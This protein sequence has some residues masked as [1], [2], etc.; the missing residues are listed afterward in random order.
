MQILFDARACFKLVQ[1]ALDSAS[2]SNLIS[3]I[4][5][6]VDPIDLAVAEGPM[7]NNVE[8][9]YLHIHLALGVFCILNPKPID[10]YP[11]LNPVHVL[12]PNCIP[13]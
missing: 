1:G 2:A 8:R 4:K 7:I 5:K 11:T 10:T 6:L 12:V 3:S 9:W 13:S